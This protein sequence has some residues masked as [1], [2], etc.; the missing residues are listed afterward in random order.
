MISTGHYASN[1]GGLVIYLNKKWEYKLQIDVTESKLWEKQIIEIF[2]INKTQRNK[3]VIGNLYR[4]PYNLRDSLD[5]FMIEFNSTLLE[6]HN[7]GQIKVHIC[8]DYNVD[9]LKSK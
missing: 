7:K 5:T 3:L 8:R 1:H 2:D 6:H 4:P 9:L